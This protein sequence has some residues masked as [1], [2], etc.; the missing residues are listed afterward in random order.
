MRRPTIHDIARRAGVAKSTVSFALNGQPG[1]SES[2][3]RRILGV[4]DELGWRPSS[5]ARSLSSAQAGAVG[6]VLACETADPA[7]MRLVAGFES[8]FGPR[9]VGLLL[10]FAPRTELAVYHSWWHQRRVDGVLVVDVRVSDPRIALLGELGLPA[11]TLGRSALPSVSLDAETAMRTA[12]GHLARLGHRRIA[13]IGRSPELV[14]TAEHTAAFL[15]AARAMAM[16]SAVCVTAEPDAAEAVRRLLAARPRPT[17]LVCDTDVMALGALGVAAQL[18]IRVPGELS[19]LA[20]EDSPLCLLPHPALT[21]VRVDL[22]SYGAA[23]AETLR[24]L[25]A[26]D[27]PPDRT[28]GPPCLVERGSTGPPV[29]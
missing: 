21:A 2:T 13:R 19:V 20:G 11:V 29:S 23:A 4:A 10:Q 9:E 18:G 1:V 6:L 28:F 26:G 5:V 15:D 27:R 25:L 14:H 7:L 3:R 16:E 24:C 12:V 8:V 17:A 22:H